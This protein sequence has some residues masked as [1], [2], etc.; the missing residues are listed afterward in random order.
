[1]STTIL[2]SSE[3]NYI[4][5]TV[6]GGLEKLTAAGATATNNG[7]SSASTAAAAALPDVTAMARMGLGG[8]ALGMLV[9]ANV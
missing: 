7:V 6:T 9:L 4:P 1:V 2:A 8:A 5:V 3:I